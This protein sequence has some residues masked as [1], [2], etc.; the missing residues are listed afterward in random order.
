MLPEEE[1]KKLVALNKS[2]QI[3]L[4][5]ANTV[6]AAKDIQIEFLQNQMAEATAL[7]S[8]IDE[9]KDEIENFHYTLY[10]KEQQ[11]S[12]AIERET[13]LQ[14]E[15]TELARLNKTYNELLQN[16]TYLSS[17]FSDAQARLTV[18]NERN[19]ELEQIAGKIGELESI[20]E[21]GKMEKE[22]LKNR[23]TILESQKYLR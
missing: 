10:K 15:L 3:Q 4:E 1:I 12:G 5:D 17:R 8:E 23:I 16:Y 21:N 13:G 19:I 11:A 7:R 9:Q 6:L 22:D 2:L 14:K 20:L 18:L